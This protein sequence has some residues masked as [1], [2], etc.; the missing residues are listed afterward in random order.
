MRRSL[1]WHISEVTLC[2]SA[3]II[4]YKPHVS[5]TSRPPPELIDGVPR[6]RPGPTSSRRSHSSQSSLRRPWRRE[7]ETGG[8]R[9]RGGT[10]RRVGGRGG[11]R[12]SASSA[13]QTECWPQRARPRP[14]GRPSLQLY[15]EEEQVSLKTRHTTANRAVV[16]LFKHN[17]RP[18]VL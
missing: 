5:V 11:R 10:A 4:I 15:L 12:P 13:S 8:R 2:K 1:W 16:L 3:W 17:S 7:P 18:L 9:R 14:V 6:E